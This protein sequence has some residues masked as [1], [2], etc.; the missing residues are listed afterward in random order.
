MHPKLLQAEETQQAAEQ[1]PSLHGACKRFPPREESSCLPPAAAVQA[2]LEQA[3]PEYCTWLG[4][5]QALVRRQ[6]EELPASVQVQAGQA[7]L[8]A[9]LGDNVHC[10]LT[11]AVIL[12]TTHLPHASSASPLCSLGKSG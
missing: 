10:P 7:F 1:P 8:P 6:Q 11:A 12:G 9:E 2:S 5:N 4:D 3:G